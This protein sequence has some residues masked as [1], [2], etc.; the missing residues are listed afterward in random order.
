MDFMCVQKDVENYIKER[1]FEEAI[2][3]IL[4]CA[5]DNEDNLNFDKSNENYFDAHLFKL[6][7]VLKSEKLTEIYK[8]LCE[9]FI[10]MKEPGLIAHFITAEFETGGCN[11]FYAG[12]AIFYLIKNY[13]LDYKDFYCNF[14][15]LIT[16]SCIDKYSNEIL[17]FTKIILADPGISL[18]CIKSYIK[19]LAR[20]S[21]DTT[22]QNCYNILLLILFL[23]K[24]NPLCGIMAHSQSFDCSQDDLEVNFE[25]FQPYLFEL[26]I[27]EKSIDPIK[28]V[29]HNIRNESQYS[30]IRY[31]KEVLL[32]ENT[33]KDLNIKIFK[34]IIKSF[35][36]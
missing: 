6:F 33:F 10:L 18:L 12:Q 28:S 34:G 2:H 16:P 24:I 30:R 4:E 3:K 31:K 1:N 14:Y 19:K 15:N 26:D 17:S 23:I 7:T 25:H 29:V 27:L 21:L 5:L 11:A 8:N 22:S 13:K 35:Y 9:I 20:T 36:E 32:S